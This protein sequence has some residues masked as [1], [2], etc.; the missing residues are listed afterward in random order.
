M[1]YVT[2]RAPLNAANLALRIRKA[3]FA[4]KGA[5]HTHGAPRLS[6]ELLHQRA[7]DRVMMQA[8]CARGFA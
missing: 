3:L 8:I 6:E 2:D 1:A 7:L 4:G 5:Q